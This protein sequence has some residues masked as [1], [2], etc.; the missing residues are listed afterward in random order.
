MLKT[1]HTCIISVI[2]SVLPL[3]NVDV[4]LKFIQA[5]KYERESYLVA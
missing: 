4:R 5:L 1:V 2:V 3:C